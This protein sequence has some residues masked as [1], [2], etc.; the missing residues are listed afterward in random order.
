MRLA[1]D[2]A[3]LLIFF[4]LSPFRGG[5]VIERLEVTVQFGGGGIANRFGDVFYRSG[6]VSQHLRGDAAT[7]AVEVG[8][9]WLTIES[10][11]AS[12]LCAFLCMGGGWQARADP[13]Q[14]YRRAAARRLR[15]ARGDG[16]C[17]G[18]DFD[19]I[20]ICFLQSTIKK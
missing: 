13:G 18:C 19:R 14:S 11:K 17:D 4:A 7:Q 15:L 1:F 9:R 16:A 8:V 12:S 2:S 5:S 10:G 20:V 6:G 3:F